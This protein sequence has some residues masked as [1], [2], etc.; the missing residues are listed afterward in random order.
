MIKRILSLSIFF[1]FTLGF[2]QKNEVNYIVDFI[3]TKQGL[4]HNYVSS[5]LSDSLNMKW[6]GTEN[7]ITKFDGYGFNYFKP[8]SQYKQLQ[9]ENIE[10]L[11]LDRE[12]NLWIG[13]K[14]GGLSFL[15]IKK[16]TIKNLNHLIDLKN[17]GDLRVTAI[18]QDIK[19]YIWVGTWQ[20]GVFVIDFKNEKLL[21]HYASNEVVYSIKSDFRNNIWFSRGSTLSHYHMVDEKITNFKI[22]GRITDILDDV[23]RRKLWIATSGKNTKLYNY[24][25]KTAT[26]DFIETT[27]TS[28]FSR[29]L[30]L[31][32]YNRLWI[33]TWG[34]GVYRSD[35][36]L[37]KFDKI[38]VISK[39]SQKVSSNYSTILNI[40]HDKNN[41]MW[42]STA[43]G[44]VVKL[45]E[46]SGFKNANKHI[47]NEDLRQNLNCTA[48]LKTIKTLFVGTF[49]GLYAGENF[50]NLKKVKTIGSTKI[51]ALYEH[52]GQ[53]YIGTASGFYIYD[54]EQKKLTYYSE[55]SNNKITSFLVDKERL[56]IGTQQLGLMVVDLK[57][58][59]DKKSYI[60]YSEKLV[61]KQKIESNRI[62]AIE[63]DQ[64][65]NIWV[66]TY[67]G[68]HLYDRSTKTFKHQSQLLDGQL[69]SAIINSILIKGN[70]IWLA[71]PSGLIKLHNLYNKL[72][73][74]DVITQK[75]GLNS[76]FICAVTY[77][78]NSELWLSTNTEIA[79][80]NENDKS[81]INYNEINGVQSTSFNN[82][83]FFNYKNEYVYFGGIDNITYFE[84]SAIRDFSTI[85]EVVFTNLK[86]NNETITYS[87]NDNILNS[88]FNYA[89]NIELSHKQNF[90]STRFVA[91]D[92]LGPLNIKYRYLIEGYKNE[93][94]NL[95]NRNEINFAGLS[96]GKYTLKVQASR[97]NQIWSAPKTITIKLLRSPWLSPFLL[98]IY[99]I[100]I[101]GIIAYIVITYNYRSKLQN[102]LEIARIDKEKEMELTEAKLNFFTNISHE[103]RTPL[104]LIISPLK[105]LLDGEKLPVKAYKNLTYIDRNT[106][107]LLNLINQLLDFRKADHG[108]LKLNA[109]N[110]NFVRFSNEVYLYFKEAAEA[111]KIKYKFKAVK[112]EILFP[113]DRNKM[114]IV[115][116]NLISNALKYT[117]SG[118]KITI[119]VDSDSEFC[120]ISI[121]D[122]GIGMKPEDTKKVFD[123]FFQI[124]SASTARLIGSGIGLSF[125][126]KIVE[127]HRGTITVKSKLNKGSVFTV[128]LALNPNLNVSEID[129]T[130]MTTDNI[131]GYDINTMPTVT[132]QLNIKVKEHSVLIIDDNS[133]ILSYLK[134]ILTESYNVI[135]AN[136]GNMGL[137]KASNEIPDL[138]I[139][140]VMMPGKDGIT[141]CKELKSQITTSHIPVILLTARTSTVF[142]I[143]GLK[144]GA[145]DYVTKPF[146][147]SVIKARVKSLLENR[148]KLRAHLLNKVRFEPTPQEVENTG[149]TENT[150]IN[151]ALLLVE[152]NLDNSEFGIDTMVDHLNM[153]Q[154]TLYR[155]IKSLTGLSLTAFIRS[156]RLKKAAHLI[157]SSD[158]NMSQV[159]YEVGFN[160]YKYFKTSF[161][162]QFDCLPSKYKALVK[163][164]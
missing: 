100:L 156:V 60:T 37:S 132:E 28:N 13:T 149:N 52:K 101:F 45:T 94:I 118:D 110:G 5:F 121:K 64:K 73:I 163:K 107:R 91:N 67:N 133:E 72:I 10:T 162:K 150:F 93:W 3:T 87:A 74:E 130:F 160:D 99:A 84:P 15:D 34:N 59:T 90:F 49:N 129:D 152:T 117:K 161:K 77:G 76:D 138:I 88:N 148:E 124:K 155:K 40:H 7:G 106:N 78:K 38:D 137:E 61:G 98:F 1:V 85:P 41:V 24:N 139:S 109:S 142:E 23:K 157:L 21:Q 18:A 103:F 80:Y 81:I 47:V 97:N 31:D 116:C 12:S 134:D 50:S 159:A 79:R 30:A 44:G 16:N 120:T 43:N 127:L 35:G 19:G 51:N 27:I 14:S 158:L 26:I 55:K 114:E 86:V 66:S 53:L 141:L 69:P 102:N 36:G 89:N 146:N 112:D 68:L 33:G 39:N 135:Q 4:S 46:S 143:E 113:F 111:K 125:S 70:Y 151:K 153:S 22:K 126:K 75:N 122:S 119:E 131:K 92:F 145:D 63:K 42:L 2:A 8:N 104:T 54:L 108:L 115:L 154:S 65:N 17:D 136:D 95:Q 25:Y 9:N 71:T 32:Q 58:I 144:T 105:E 48:I 123:R 164:Q 29:K 20:N 56:F 62:T 140:D 82:H 128:K 147:S 57:N 6:I 11:F 96:A 83:S